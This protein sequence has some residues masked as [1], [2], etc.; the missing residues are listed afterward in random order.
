MTPHDPAKSLMAKAEPDEVV[1]DK[2][3]LDPDVPVEMLGFHRQRTVE[4]LRKAVLAEN[5]ATTPSCSTGP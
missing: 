3:L 1:V 4:E 5:P 2:L